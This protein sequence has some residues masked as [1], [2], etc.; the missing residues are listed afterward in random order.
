ML[1]HIL[2]LVKTLGRTYT[3]EEHIIAVTGLVGDH[4]KIDGLRT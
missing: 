1:D 3:D 4:H 2:L